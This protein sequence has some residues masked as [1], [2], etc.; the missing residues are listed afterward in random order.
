MA[1][2]IL[3]FA[4]R[5]YF[6]KIS[7]TRKMRGVNHGDDAGGE[8]VIEGV[9]VSGDAGHE[10]ADGVA[11]EVGHGQALQ[12][13]KDFAAHVVHG[14]LTDALHDADLDVLGKKVESQDKEIDETDPDQAHF[15]LGNGDGLSGPR[16][17][18]PIDGFAEEQRGSQFQGSDY[19]NQRKRDDD[20]PFVRPHVLQE[21]LH[22]ARVVRLAECLFFVNIAHARSNSS[23]SNCF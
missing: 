17:E 16:D 5:T 6:R 8:Q 13:A 10:A 1:V 2:R 15:C 19:G 12:A 20:T 21:P 22:Q 23:S 3:R 11:V 18:I 9:H 7:V 4:S 14:F